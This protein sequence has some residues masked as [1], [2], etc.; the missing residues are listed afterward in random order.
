[1]KSIAAI[2]LKLFWTGF[3]LLTSIYCLLTFLPY[4]YAALI[5]APAYEWMPWFVHHHAAL[6]WFGCIG[7]I[8]CLARENK[9]RY[10]LALFSILSV[11][12]IGLLVHPVLA[13]LRSDWMALLWSLVALFLLLLTTVPELQKQLSREDVAKSE[14]PLLGY[15]NAVLTAAL[16][17]LIYSASAQQRLWGDASTLHTAAANLRL[18]LWSLA[19]HLLVALIVVSILNLVFLVAARFSRPRRMRLSLIVLLT[20]GA[21]WT[22]IALF[23]ANALSFEGLTAQLFAGTL[24]CAI[25]FSVFSLILP[26]TQNQDGKS[27][28][29]RVQAIF[30]LTALSLVAVAVGLPAWTTG[31]DWNGVIA[32]TY[33]LLFW[34]TLTALMY[35]LRPDRANYNL[36]TILAVVIIAI[37][38]YKGLQLTGIFWSQPL[39]Q[40]DDDI[41]RALETYAAED[42]SFQLTRHLVTNSRREPCGDLCRI[43]R[44]YTD[45]RDASAPFDVQLVKKLEPTKADKP[46]IF[47]F[48]IDSLRP[49]YLGA[50]NSKVDFSPNLD[51]FA[52]D[53]VVVRNAFTQYA[54]TTLSE[55]AIWSGTMLLHSHYMQPFSRV[56]ALEKLARTD[57][58]QMVISYDTVLR[59]LLAP[60]D[61]IVK[62]DTD[63]NLWGR[64]EVCST[65]EQTEHA[66]EARRDQSQPVLFYAQPM[67]VHQFARNNLPGPQQTGWRNRAGFNNRIAYEVH[68][69]DD[70]MGRFFSYLK[71]RG[72]Y[73]SSIIVLTSDHGDAT[74]EFGRRSHSISIYPEIMRVPLVVHLPEKLRSRVKHDDSRVSLLT[75]ITPS[76]YYLLGHRPVEVNPM[77]GIPIF[78]DHDD[79]WSERSK[80]I[81]LASDVRAAYGI[82]ADNGRYLYV[83]Y[84]SPAKSQLWDLKNDPNAVNDIL[85]PTLKKRYDERIIEHL[86]AIA[87]FYDYK[88]GM[89]SL[90][91]SKKQ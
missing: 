47:I 8:F 88:P 26:L 31:S 63:K 46:N 42:A 19:T 13:G 71:A 67:N 7:T 62:L 12:G 25:A 59:E 40:T 80:D 3:L 85:T 66:L 53:S 89:G 28:S 24:A 76:L 69:V 48:V 33:T 45:I 11:A 16:V 34:V 27:H 43:L 15:A 86:H 54:G 57:N 1:L 10:H 81:L 21:L 91:A 84:D 23:L 83:T 90:L 61:N 82:L 75:D 44:E 4:T 64:F 50:Y 29:R 77:F 73:D 41:A 55:P 6:Y 79:Q 5:K 51:S 36:A 18:T 74:G 39:G 58:Y 32:N 52:R 68:Q 65:I 2:V 35:L 17:A 60:S 87:D 70:C 72:M 22:A 49:D 38:T 56:N 78:V 30:G 9:S 14:K 20:V 37:S